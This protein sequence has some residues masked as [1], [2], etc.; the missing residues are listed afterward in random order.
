M[1]DATSIVLISFL[2]V[3]SI[4]FISL[5]SFAFCRLL[6]CREKTREGRSSRGR[7]KCVRPRLSSPIYSISSDSGGGKKTQSFY[8][9]PS[10]IPDQ[11]E[12]LDVSTVREP[13]ESRR[14][15]RLSPPVRDRGVSKGRISVLNECPFASA[16]PLGDPSQYSPVNEVFM[17]MPPQLRRTDRY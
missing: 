11:R 12:Y 13:R 17:Y 8:G 2:I 3:F 7:S 9:S 10:P 14:R 1:L 5:A 4:A 15:D 6:L 16:P